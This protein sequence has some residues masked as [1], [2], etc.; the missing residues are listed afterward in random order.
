MGPL[1][2]LKGSSDW[3]R[4]V[5]PFSSKE[6]G[7]PP[8]RLDLN[9]VLPG[10]GTVYLGSLRLVQYGPAED[11]AATTGQWWDGRFPGLF[12]G[13]LGSLVGC[14]GALIGW[15][16]STGKARRVA[17]G[18]TKF[19]MLLGVLALIAG[20]IALGQSQPYAVFYPLLLIGG[21]CATLPAALFGSIRKRYEEMELRTMRARTPLHAASRTLA[22][23]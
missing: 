23:Q 14:L 11:P 15:L 4:F 7:P 6:G 16:T 13:I 22:A 20:G 12:G 21:L 9:V 18:A 2:S 19:M 8:A 1:K 17:L 10:R 5:I 3:R